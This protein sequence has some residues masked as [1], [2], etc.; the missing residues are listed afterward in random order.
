MSDTENIVNAEPSSSEKSPNSGGRRHNKKTREVVS[1]DE[2][3]QLLVL[4]MVEFNLNK[5]FIKFTNSRMKGKCTTEVYNSNILRVHS[6]RSLYRTELI[7]ETY[8]VI[9]NKDINVTMIEQLLEIICK[10]SLITFDKIKL[11]IRGKLVMGIN[12]L[13]KSIGEQ[14]SL[15]V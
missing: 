2:L 9:T 5:T 3:L 6:A 10:Y 14:P 4:E 12:R 15:I 8:L 1:R 7:P 11:K 13:Q